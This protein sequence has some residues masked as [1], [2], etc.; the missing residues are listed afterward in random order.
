MP[1]PA[2]NVLMIGPPGSG[3]TMLAQRFSGFFHRSASTRPWKTSKV[4][5]VAGMLNNNP[6]IVRRQFRV[7]ITPYPMQVWSAAATSQAGEGQPRPQRGPFPGRIPGVPS[8][9]VDLLRQPLEDGRV[10]IARA[11]I[12]LTYTTIL[13]CGCKWLY[14]AFRVSEI[15]VNLDFAQVVGALQNLGDSAAGPPTSIPVVQLLQR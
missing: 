2:H 14:P 1:L 15:F 8:K 10:T 13:G 9:R 4:F 12:A 11:A 3:K 5:S 7:L 6:L